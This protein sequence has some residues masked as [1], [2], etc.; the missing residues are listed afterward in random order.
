M[1]QGPETRPPAAAARALEGVQAVSGDIHVVWGAGRFQRGEY[2]FY[3]GDEVRRQSAGGAPQEPPV[4][5]SNQ[6]LLI[7]LPLNLPITSLSPT[8]NG[9]Q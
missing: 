8:L 9:Q 4:P 1:R 7:P 2:L 6:I 3:A 5:H